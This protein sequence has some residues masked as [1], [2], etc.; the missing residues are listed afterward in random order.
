MA[1]RSPCLANRHDL[2]SYPLYEFV[3]FS[4]FV[5]D[6]LFTENQRIECYV[7]IYDNNDWHVMECHE[8]W[9]SIRERYWECRSYCLSVSVSLSLSLSL[10]LYLRRCISTFLPCAAQ[11]R[12]HWHS[13]F[14]FCSCVRR[15]GIGFLLSFKF[16]Y[17]HQNT[18]IRKNF[19][20]LQR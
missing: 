7:R 17:C 15:T 4:G 1:Q 20:K 16:S 13:K 3:L 18:K 6:L 14:R 10:F 9:M 12:C 19:I 8:E 5:I 11:H 2:L